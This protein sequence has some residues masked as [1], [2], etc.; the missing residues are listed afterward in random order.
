VSVDFVAPEDVPHVAE[1]LEQSIAGRSSRAAVENKMGEKLGLSAYPNSKREARERAENRPVSD[2]AP[3]GFGDEPSADAA[4]TRTDAEKLE[5][6]LDKLFGTDKPQQPEQQPQDRPV[7]QERPESTQQQAEQRIP[8]VN[9]D[10]LWSEADVQA[11]V[12]YETGLHQL[13]SD[14]AEFNKAAEYV[15][16]I[17][18]PNARAHAEQRLQ[19]AAEHIKQSSETL[20]RMADKIEEGLKTRAHAQMRQYVAQ[21][22]E[23][24]HPALKSNPAERA[25]LR[26]WLIKEGK[27]PQE[28][29][30]AHNAWE[31]NTAYDAMRFRLQSQSKPKAVRR[32]TRKVDDRAKLQR[33]HRTGNYDGVDSALDRRL[34]EIFR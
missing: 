5:D 9:P 17:A 8:G 14:I 19:L 6:G 32:V 2:P 28:I 24:L 23:K 31:L 16:Q 7:A 25:K 12:Q 22:Q 20:G 18:D 33:A 10:A 4:D 3:Y 30:A 29:D 34:G 11:R 27:N 13:N 21:Q 26:D 15:A 1:Y